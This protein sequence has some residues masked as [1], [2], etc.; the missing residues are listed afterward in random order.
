MGQYSKAETT[1]V[2]ARDIMKKVA[3]EGPLYATAVN[4]LVT[5][6]CEQGL[7]E[8]AK[9]LSLLCCSTQK[10]LL[11]KKCRVCTCVE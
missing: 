8:K 9:P 4:N 2:Q 10:K 1:F 5:L 6:Y 11:V 3:G 7:F